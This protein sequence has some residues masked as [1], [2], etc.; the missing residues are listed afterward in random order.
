MKENILKIL[1]IYTLRDI[2]FS[3]SFSYL[4]QGIYNGIISFINFFFYSMI[5]IGPTIIL[6]FIFTG[7]P[8]YFILIKK[9]TLTVRVFLLSILVLI[10]LIF[11]S[12]LF[13]L[14]NNNLFS[15][16]RVILFTISLI[17][18]FKRD[19]FSKTSELTQIARICNPCPQQ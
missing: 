13:N 15:L 14:S 11:N 17:L 3:I 18:I 2:I 4:G 8:A 7:I 5:F 12:I 16:I 19:F 10:D 9:T 6:N 1:L